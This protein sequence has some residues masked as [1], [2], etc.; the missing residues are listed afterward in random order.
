MLPV[1]N[2]RS[3]LAV[4]F[5]HGSVYRCPFA[6][7]CPTLCDPVDCSTQASLSLTISRGL[8]KFM[9]FESV[10]PSN[11]LIFGRPLSPSPF[12]LSQCR[13]LCQCFGHVTRKTSLCVSV[14][15]S[16]FIPPPVLVAQP[17]KNPPAMWETWVRSLGWEDPLEKG[18]ATHF[19]ILAWRTPWMSPWG[20]RELD[21]TER[22]SLH[23][24]LVFT[25]C[26][27]VPP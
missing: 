5:T 19:S 3:P 21:A 11:R 2:S 26:L 9:S 6:K 16:Q 17:V 15:S 8:P 10:M 14:Q 18:K 24:T 1:L 4:C 27:S 13:D 25:Y 20:H 7:S 23:F 12:S 22:L